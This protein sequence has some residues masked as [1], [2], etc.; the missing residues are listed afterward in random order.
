MSAVIADID[1]AAGLTKTLAGAIEGLGLAL[2][3]FRG[4]QSQQ[5]S[6]SILSEAAGALVDAAGLTQLKRLA[7][8]KKAADQEALDALAGFF[9]ADVGAG[10]SEIDVTRFPEAKAPQQPREIDTSGFPERRTT[11]PVQSLMERFAAEDRAQAERDAM[12]QQR[13]AEREAREIA[14]LERRAEFA[15][16]Q[17]LTEQEQIEARYQFELQDLQRR[18]LAVADFE[19]LRAQLSEQRDRQILQSRQRTN[20]ALAAGAAGAAEAIFGENKLTAIAQTVIST[21]TAVMR[22]LE[23]YGPTPAGFAASAIAVAQGA[24]SLAAIRSTSRGGGGGV[25]GGGSVSGGAGT[26]GGGGATLATPTTSGAASVPTTQEIVIRRQGADGLRYTEEEVQ[27]I[28]QGIADVVNDGGGQD[29]RIA[30][31]AG[32]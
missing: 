4:S 17:T 7:G 3:E 25:S 5:I 23:I 16:L 29:L 28:I 30:V 26:A 21:R 9:G 18:Q 12:E 13:L 2:G 19:R 10:V 1:K 8:A 20:Q 24:A 15:R 22:A 32:G 31:V 11:D 6:E 27:Q 14:F